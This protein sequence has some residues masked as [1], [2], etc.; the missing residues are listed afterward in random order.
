MWNMLNTIS[1]LQNF[2]PSLWLHISQRHHSDMLTLCSC[3]PIPRLESWA[4]ALYSQDNNETYFCNKQLSINRCSEAF[5]LVNIPCWCLAL[6]DF[7][8][9]HWT[10][11]WPRICNWLMCYHLLQDCTTTFGGFWC[12][13]C[14]DCW[15][16]QCQF[17]SLHGLSLHGLRHIATCD[18]MVENFCCWGNMI[19]SMLKHLRGPS[20]PWMQQFL[21]Y[22]WWTSCSTS[23]WK[24]MI[25]A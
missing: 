15:L 6:V 21:T 10:H 22:L 20:N 19:P 16:Y 23:T 4:Q 9:A 25:C 3:L 8:T 14:S 2:W 13:L 11:L 5:T 1:M 12:L 18:N 17:H 7:S 24:K